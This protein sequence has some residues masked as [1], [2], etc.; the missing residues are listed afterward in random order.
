MK[1]PTTKRLEE[2]VK[3]LNE[4]GYVKAKEL[5]KKYEV[6]METI[7]KDLTYLEKKGVAKKEYGGATLSP[8]SVEKSI[9]YRIN[10]EKNKKEIAKLAISFLKEH[11]VMILDSGTTCQACVQY[12]NRLP[13]MDIVTNSIISFEQLNGNI[14]NVFL[15]GGKKREK[16]LSL[17]GNWSELF[18]K[19]IQVDICLLGTA[20]F[21]GSDG[22]TAH[23]Y[24]ELTTKQTMIEK[25]DMVFVLAESNKFLEKGFHTVVGWDKIDGIITDHNLSLKLYEKY[26]KIVPIYMAEEGFY[27]EDS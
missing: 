6:S 19:R 24:Q 3:L 10:G 26:S 14:H 7:R 25:S 16:N 20:G 23:S 9:E 8:L 21:L 5:S 18:L 17:I 22:P 15:T 13:T 1:L 2:I 27:E 4:N 12:I 11:H